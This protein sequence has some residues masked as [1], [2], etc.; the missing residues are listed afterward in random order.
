MAK[1]SVGLFL[2]RSFAEA[3]LIV[4]ARNSGYKRISYKRKEFETPLWDQENTKAASMISELVASLPGKAKR[5]DVNVMVSLPDPLIRETILQFDRF[6]QNPR[7]ATDL[8]KWRI[9]TDAGAQARD[10]HC[11]YQVIQET[12]ET[13]RVIG[14]SV[15]QSVFDLTKDAIEAG[16]GKIARLDGWSGFHF[17]H[18]PHPR[19][20]IC[21]WAN[22]EWW[23]L[24]CR[25]DHT[26][27]SFVASGWI[28]QSGSF[29]RIAERIT[30][31]A[32]AFVLKTSGKPKYV[33][34]EVP[35]DFERV[36]VSNLAKDLLLSVAGVVLE[37]GVDREPSFLV[38]L[39]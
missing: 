27:E 13:V 14:R 19:A 18:W 31:L 16:G 33:I 22:K 2:G 30:R 34:L 12:N 38:A 5:A 11:S 28:D 37:S 15:D 10:I 32:R 35:Q 3:S 17:N 23:I 1:M 4:G 39:P 36:L 29:D 20:E 8:V 7:E 25:H 6:P 21:I 26:G 24:E 9:T